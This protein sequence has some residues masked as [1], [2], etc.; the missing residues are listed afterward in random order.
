MTI[1]GENAEPTLIA[2]DDSYDLASIENWD[3][4]ERELRRRTR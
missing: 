4:L 2:I 1:E 3:V